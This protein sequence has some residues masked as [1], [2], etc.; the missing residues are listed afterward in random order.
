MVM[1][2]KELLKKAIELGRIPRYVYKYRKLETFT[3]NIFSKNEIWFEK[4]VNFNDPFDCKYSYEEIPN[5]DLMKQYIQKNFKNI[6][7]EDLDLNKYK[8]LIYA[9]LNK[10][11]KEIISN[12]GLS[13]FSKNNDNILMWSHYAD[14]HKGVCIKFDMLSDLDFFMIP[15]EIV[16]KDEYPKFDILN[17]ENEN[18]YDSIYKIKANC[19]KYEEEVR[20]RKKKSGLHNFNKNCLTDIYF[21]LNTTE[22]DVY[23]Y[24][25]ILTDY[26]YQNVGLFK[27]VPSFNQYKIN[28]KKI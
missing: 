13:C 21:G 16:Y 22:D 20:I 17:S 3:E 25:K 12:D 23:K 27:A 24:R 19:W 9:K 18:L 11:L 7:I 4:P 6:N 14:S 8:E 2:K 5:V 10:E 28:F 1:S 15:I 26:S